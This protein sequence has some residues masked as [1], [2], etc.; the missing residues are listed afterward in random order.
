MLISCGTTKKIEAL[1]PS[2][3][4]DAPIVFKNKTSFVAMPITISL[5]EIEHQLNK[6]L[7]GLIY[8]DS[9][10]NDDKT[11]MKIWKK[12]MKSPKKLWKS[13]I[14]EHLRL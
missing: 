2:P 5:S 1:K 12:L 9:L 10:M 13:A 7:T 11:Q 6:K 3:S 8:N 4:N 14:L